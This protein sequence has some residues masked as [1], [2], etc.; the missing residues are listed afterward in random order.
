M[1]FDLSDATQ[2]LQAMA[3]GFVQRLPY[4]ML[5]LLGSAALSSPQTR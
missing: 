2:A 4:L 1:N 3:G 5:A